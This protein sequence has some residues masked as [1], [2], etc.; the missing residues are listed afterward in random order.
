MVATASTERSYI[1]WR[2]RLLRELALAF[3]A[4]FVYATHAMQAIA[5]GWKPGFSFIS[6]VKVTAPSVMCTIATYN[7]SWT[8]KTTLFLDYVRNTG[9]FKN[10]ETRLHT[11]SIRNISV[12]LVL[13]CLLNLRNTVSIL[14]FI[15]N[16]YIKK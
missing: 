2:L 8:L 4:V 6:L 12:K 1:G 9:P 13:H 5:F 11:F 3:L 16:N 10:Y 14:P 7:G 15:Y